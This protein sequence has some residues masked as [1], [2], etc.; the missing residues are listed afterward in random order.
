MKLSKETFAKMSNNMALLDILNKYSE[1]YNLITI[2]R[3]AGFLAQCSHESGDFKTLVENL[4]YSAESLNKVFKKYFSTIEAAKPYHRQPEK[5]ANKV[6][7]SRMGNGPE[8]SGDG[9]RYRGRGAI[10]L[11]GKNNYSEFAAAKNISLDECVEYLTTIEGSIESAMWFWKTR[12]LNEFCDKDDIVGMT[13]RINGGTNGL[14]HRTE[15]YNKFKEIITK[16]N[17]PMM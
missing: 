9:W 2:N 1:E 6:Y 5:I 7:G 11:T 15:L 13:K 8:S 17:V 14:A 4:N 10:Q 16:D 12:L 3:M